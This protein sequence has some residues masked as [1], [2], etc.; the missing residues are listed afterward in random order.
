MRPP[1]PLEGLLGARI[2]F[3]LFG[4][5]LGTGHIRLAR[6]RSRAVQPEPDTESEEES[7]EESEPAQ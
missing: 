6:L 5:W 3:K 2:N 4:I 1:T 7:E